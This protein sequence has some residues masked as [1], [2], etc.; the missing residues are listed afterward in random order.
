MTNT[1]TENSCKLYQNIKVLNPDGEHLFMCNK[2]RIRWYQKRNLIDKVGEDTFMLKFHPKGAQLFTN[3]KSKKFLLTP[4]ENKCVVCGEREITKLNKHHVVPQCYRKH[5][6]VELKSKNNH[7][8]LMICESCHIAYERIA[9]L[10]KE[11]IAKDCGISIRELDRAYSMN[12][13]H[14]QM[15]KVLIDHV[16]DVPIERQIHLYDKLCTW[17][18]KTLTDAELAEIANL[19]FE[20]ESAIVGKRVVESMDNLHEF[21]VMW[22]KHFIEVMNPQHLPEGWSINY[23]H[24]YHVEC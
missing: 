2:R 12:V 5:Y 17:A 23:K 3:E 20:N 4:K 22:R 1:L 21:S 11:K 15:A 16:D 13:R 7:D 19:Q 14:R 9:T 8:V 18:G 6:P 10:K 24:Y